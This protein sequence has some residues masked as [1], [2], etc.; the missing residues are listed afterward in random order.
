MRRST[1]SCSLVKEHG[2][3]AEDVEEVEIGLPETGWKIIGGPEDKTNPKSVV[4]GTVLHAV[5]RRGGTQGR[6]T[7]LGRL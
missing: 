2:I 5:L 4:D 1:E 3:S 7:C 6:G